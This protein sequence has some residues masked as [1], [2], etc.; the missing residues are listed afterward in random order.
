MGLI[1][2]IFV[3]KVPATGDPVV[4]RCLTVAEAKEATKDASDYP[5]VIVLHP[6]GL[7]EHH[8]SKPKTPTWD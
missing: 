6:H 8:R 4:V 1:D 3:K 7:V 5:L 2:P